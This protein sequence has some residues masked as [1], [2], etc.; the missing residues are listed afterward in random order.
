MDVPPA[1][2]E[3]PQQQ[4]EDTHDEESA[5]EEDGEIMV[6]QKIK[7]VLFDTPILRLV[8]IVFGATL[9]TLILNP[10]YSLLGMDAAAKVEAPP[11]VP[12]LDLGPELP[13]A[14]SLMVEVAEEAELGAEFVAETVS[15]IIAPSAKTNIVRSEVKRVKEVSKEAT[16]EEVELESDAT[17][18]VNAACADCAPSLVRH[19]EVASVIT[20]EVIAEEAVTD[21]P[22]K[23]EVPQAAGQSIM[24]MQPAAAESNEASENET[25]WTWRGANLLPHIII[26]VVVLI[27]FVI[28]LRSHLADLLQSLPE[29]VVR[30]IRT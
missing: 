19:D 14:N 21:V 3:V 9:I 30:K 24:R 8:K 4:A 5:D 10:P 18:V 22:Q 1:E 6:E 28:H 23:V 13:S 12:K 11:A 29:M 7:P 15:A 26:A 2:A 25:P 16:S 17:H 27:G 20:G